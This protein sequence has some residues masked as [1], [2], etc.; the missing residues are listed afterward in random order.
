MTLNRKQRLL[1]KAEECEVR[2]AMAADKLFE[3]TY[4][5]LA[6]QWRGM[7]HDLELI[8]ETKKALARSRPH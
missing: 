4:Y 7:A 2:A 5:D 3:A 8:E 1:A 6:L